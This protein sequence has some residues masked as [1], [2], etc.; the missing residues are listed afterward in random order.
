MSAPGP[1]AVTFGI[2][3]LFAPKNEDQLVTIRIA[4]FDP[5]TASDELWAAFNETR[6]AIAHELW[7][8]EPTLDDAE[9]RREVQ[10]NNPM[11][12][13]RR[14]VAM[15]GDEV[16]GS[17]R[18][19][20]RRAGTPDE[21]DYARFVWAGGGVRASSRRRGVGTL[22]LRE[23]YRLMHALDKSV[24][25]MSAQSEPAH[26]FIKHVGAVEKHCRVEQRAV[27]ADLDW[28]LLRQWEDGA[29]AQGL[30]WER[31]AGR[32]PRDVLVALLPV[33]TELFADVPLGE[34]ESGPIRWEMN[35]YDLWYETLKR[36]GGA[37]HLVL[38]CAPDGAVT[39]LSEAGW[40]ARTPGI[41]RQQLTA[42]ARPWRS[43]GVGRALK[44]AML[45][46]VHEMHPEATM[47]GTDNAEVN[48][49]IL[50]INAR[51]GFKIAWRNVDYQVTRA[52][53][54]S[55][56]DGGGRATNSTSEV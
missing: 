41:V 30:T 37:H 16:A 54:E 52:A 28:P 39:G 17:I 8:D 49:P 2:S 27:F 26:A 22:L 43:R 21:K 13:F 23:V 35:G 18:A 19:A 56:A 55:W 3:V 45:R 44:A 25:T 46:Q 7:P 48:A 9:T 32:V 5:H 4:P 33:F 40:D 24:L 31:Y 51:V 38:L 47:I 29:T 11:V 50:S 10:T 53:L 1:F 6:R 15:E 42:V 14:W 12:E 20:F 36:V 34:L